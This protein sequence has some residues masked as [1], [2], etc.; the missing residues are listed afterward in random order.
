MENGNG[1][2]GDAKRDKRMTTG[3]STAHGPTLALSTRQG[4]ACDP[5]RPDV[6]VAYR[7]NET[8]ACPLV[9]LPFPS[10]ST[11]TPYPCPPPQTVLGVLYLSKRR[12]AKALDVFSVVA[13]QQ[14]A[15]A[16]APNNAALAAYLAATADYDDSSAATRAASLMAQ[17]QRAAAAA[18][19]SARAGLRAG[20]GAGEWYV[21][22]GVG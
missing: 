9:L 2:R 13:Q 3:L 5:G 14:P 22:Q 8:W 12:Y 15:S 16:S 7:I 20:A 18:A 19:A 10:L 1:G 21:V 11:C 17:R 4:L 6:T